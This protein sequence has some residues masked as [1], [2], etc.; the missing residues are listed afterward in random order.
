[1]CGAL[2]SKSLIQ[3]SVDRQDFLLSLLFGLRP[4]YGGGNEENDNLLQYVPY[5]HAALHVPKLSAGQCLPT[6]IPETPILS[7]K[8]LAQSLV[9]TLFLCPGSWYTQGFVCAKSQFPQSCAS[10]VIELHWPP[11]SNSLGVLS[12][13]A[14]SLGWETCRRSQNFLT[15][16]SISLV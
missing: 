14:R 13:F 2:F 9:G 3:F 16:A 10:S 8:N 5:R 1:M 7:Q 15:S 6:P 12:P 4:N 11:R